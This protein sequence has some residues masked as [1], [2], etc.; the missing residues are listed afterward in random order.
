MTEELRH[1][2]VQRRPVG[3]VD[4][5][6]PRNWASRAVRWLALRACNARWRAAPRPRRAEHHRSVQP[7]LKELLAKYPNLTTERALQ[8]LQARL[9][10]KY[11][12]VRPHRPL[13][14]APRRHRA[15][16]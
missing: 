16:L 3:H 11:T 10:G 4:A 12:V 2:I 6:S 7:I 8:E 15:A 13:A 14:S 1:E 5:R 9:P